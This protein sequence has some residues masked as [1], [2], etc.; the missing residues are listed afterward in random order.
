[1]SVFISKTLVGIFSNLSLTSLSKESEF[2]L[3]SENLLESTISPPDSKWASWL[4]SSLSE[5]FISELD[6]Q[7]ILL[8]FKVTSNAFSFASK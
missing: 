5:Y 1:M 2:I 8:S 7:L 6:V 4:G 3:Y